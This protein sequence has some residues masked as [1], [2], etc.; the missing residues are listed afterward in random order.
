[1]FG[2]SKTVLLRGCSCWALNQSS[3]E[4][5]LSGALLLLWL[6]ASHSLSITLCFRW[7]L[8][9]QTAFLSA[10]ALPAALGPPLGA[11][12]LESVPSVH[13]PLPRLALPLLIPLCLLA[14][15]WRV[16]LCCSASAT[17][18][19][20]QKP[21]FGGWD[22]LRDPAP[23]RIRRPVMYGLCLGWIPEAS[24]GTKSSFSSL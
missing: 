20:R 18:S 5:S 10:T 15:G 3:Q 17:V 9:C 23:L 13:F 8:V 11:C 16:L 6:L 21:G 14:W 4:L 12:A 1:M 24:P 7:G 22:F 2:H 19:E